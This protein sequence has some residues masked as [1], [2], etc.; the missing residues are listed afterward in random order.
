MP[1]KIEALYGGGA[2]NI[3][4][5]ATVTGSAPSLSYSLATLAKMDPAE[6]VR[7]GSGSI[8]FTYTLPVAK[9]GG[10]FILPISNADEGEGVVT[11]SNGAGLSVA[12]P[13]L[14]W[15]RNGIPRTA[16]IDFSDQSGLTSNTWTVTFSGNS[17]NVI[18]G[19]GMGIFPRYAFPGLRWNFSY[20]H[21]QAALD[22]P[23][24]YFHR[25]RFAYRTSERQLSCEVWM[26]SAD[27]AELDDVVAG[28]AGVKPGFIWP[29]LEGIDAFFGTFPPFE[30][31]R[32]GDVL[33]RF[34][35]GF[36]FSELSKGKPV[37]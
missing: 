35:V 13:I 17:A 3:L 22:E 4:D 28:G 18:C 21:Q 12:V 19:G 20:R 23:N 33:E 7:W 5:G 1:V 14:P 9:T 24:A 34:D 25:R 15:T 26:D 31:K 27:L 29:Q 10:V 36:V 6:R 37:F 16:A 2:D 32:V 11:L 8:S 30:A